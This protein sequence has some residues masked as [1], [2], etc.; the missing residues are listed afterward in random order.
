[1]YCMHSSRTF[2]KPSVPLQKSL[3]IISLWNG[4][5]AILFKLIAQFS[6]PYISLFWHKWLNSCLFNF[7]YVFIGKFQVKKFKLLCPRSCPPFEWSIQALVSLKNYSNFYEIFIKHS[8]K[9]SK[10]SL[11]YSYSNGQSIK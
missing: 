6:Y 9:I 11:N 1:M 3:K 2:S 4:M 8:S 7:I 10:L 5:L